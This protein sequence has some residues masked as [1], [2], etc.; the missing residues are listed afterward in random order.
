[1]KIVMKN[2]MELWKIYLRSIMWFYLTKCVEKCNF[3][4]AAIE[5]YCFPN[6]FRGSICYLVAC[7]CGAHVAVLPFLSEK[8]IYSNE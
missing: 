5:A 7:W 6:F 1:M 3:F 8:G 2:L 4:S